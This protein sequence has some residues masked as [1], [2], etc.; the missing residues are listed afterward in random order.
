VLH[1]AKQPTPAMRRFVGASAAGVL[2]IGV[3]SLGFVDRNHDAKATDLASPSHEA[4]ADATTPDQALAVSYASP[5]TGIVPMGGDSSSDAVRRRSAYVTPSPGGSSTPS[6][7]APAA[8]PSGGAPASPQPAPLLPDQTC[9]LL[10]ALCP[11]VN[12][13]D[14]TVGVGANL[15][16]T[17]IGTTVT[18]NP[19]DP[20]SSTIGLT[21]GDQ[22]LIG[23]PAPAPSSPNTAV[24]TSPLGTTTLP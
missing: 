23:S 12:N 2:A 1:L 18:A 20:T 7:P 8:P 9:T 24:V 19:T 6:A 5:L 4:S 17:T 11:P 14:P 3:L 21:V 13:G 15:G 10:A 22:T 16:G